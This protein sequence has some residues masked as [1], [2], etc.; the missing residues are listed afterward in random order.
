[1]QSS[2][3]SSPALSRRA[4]AKLAMAG[5]GALALGGALAGCSQP[6]STND[7]N[8]ANAQ[9][10]TQ[11]QVIVTMPTGAEPAAGFDPFVSWGCGEHVHE[12]L[13]QST[14]I[15]TNADMSFSNDLATDYSCSEDGL[16]WTFTIREDAVFSDGEPLTAADV[17]FTINGILSSPTAEADLSMVDEA[18]ATGDYTVELHLNKPFNILLYTLANVGICPEH[19]HGSDYGTN[20]IGS[21]RYVLT[22]WDKGQQVIFDANPTYYGEKPQIERVVVLFMDE[23]ASLAAA[24]AGSVD[25]AYTS[26]TFAENIVSGYD[27][28]DC[29]TV[30][31]R[32]ISLPMIP[33]G[34]TWESSGQTYEAGNDVT[35]DLSLRQAMSVALDR[36]LAIQHTLGGF[37]TPAYSVSDGMPWAS[38][39][40]K[41]ETNVERAKQILADGGWTA[42]DD[43]ILTKGAIRAEFDLL[44]MA[45]DTVRQALCADFAEQMASLGIQ[46]NVSGLS[47]DELEPQSYSQAILWGWGSNSPIEIYELNHSEGWGDYA[48]RTSETTDSYLNQAVAQSDISD[49]YEFYRL[50][51]WD[52][53]TGVTPAADAPWVWI[54]NVDHLYFVREGLNVAEQKPHPHGHGWSIV[55]NVDKW[56]W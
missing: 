41:V 37:G 49:S 27:L 4:F 47:W 10:D 56:S 19:A 16:T 6:E 12:P 51:Q 1:M 2:T 13:I 14:L 28:F 23:D 55:N 5:G 45:P 9:G 15:V 38:D 33:A 42:G 32:G 36:D 8:A 53:T 3:S 21:G 35:S 44:Y 11:A 26:A 24:Q 50:A 29:E 22:Q 18:V 43:G 31:S 25:L 48:C 34:S 46:V 7:E 39:D 54:A 52:G 40:M 17:A 30:D 20:P